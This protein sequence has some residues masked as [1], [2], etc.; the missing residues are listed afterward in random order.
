[1]NLAG[2]A[3]SNVLN[4]LLLPQKQNKIQHP[5]AHRVRDKDE[6]G[7]M[8]LPMNHHHGKKTK[9]TVRSSANLNRSK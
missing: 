8:L 4:G 7:F 1:M 9:S 2:I 5:K 6:T 3:E